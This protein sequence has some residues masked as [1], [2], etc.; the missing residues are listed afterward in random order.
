MFLGYQQGK[1][2]YYVEKPLDSSIYNVDRWEETQDEYVLDGNEYVK[3]DEA[4]EHEQ[5]EKE[6]E[7]IQA[8]F[9]TRS[10]FFDGMIKAFGVNAEELLIVVENILATLPIQDIEKKIAVNN[11]KNALNFYRKH[12]LFTLLSNV[13]IQITP[14]LTIIITSEQ[15]DVFFDETNKRNPDAYKAL[16][17]P[18]PQPD[19]NEPSIDEEESQI[20]ESKPANEEE[21][22]E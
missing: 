21:V 4:W 14:E 5:E 20:N 1:I 8:L 7:R 11:Y 22:E 9:M 15:W 13:K 2:K 17:P 6:K 18:E 12:A 3:K 16:L 10:D 19:D